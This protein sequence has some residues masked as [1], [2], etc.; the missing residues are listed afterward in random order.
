[1]SALWS[2]VSLRED[3]EAVDR[4]E[5]CYS[6]VSTNLHDM[7]ITVT[8][9]YVDAT[10]G[11][12]DVIRAVEGTVIDVLAFARSTVSDSYWHHICPLH[13]FVCPVVRARQVVNW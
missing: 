2:H 3:A 10:G 12:A 9:P 6:D 1:M 13:P 5:T 7:S 8:R 4:S 11:S